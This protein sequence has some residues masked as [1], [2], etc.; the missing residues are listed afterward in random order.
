MATKSKNNIE[1]ALASF[2]EMA[3]SE[4]GMQGTNIL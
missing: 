4:V 2:M 1:K 3:T